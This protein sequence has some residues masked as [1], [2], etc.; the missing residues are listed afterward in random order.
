M[1]ILT[2]WQLLSNH[3]YNAWAD[4]DIIDLRGFQAEI[5]RV[6]SRTVYMFSVPKHHIKFTMSR[7]QDEIYGVLRE[8][9]EDM[10]DGTHRGIENIRIRLPWEPIFPEV[11]S[12][13]E[14][15]LHRWETDVNSRPP[16]P[17][18]AVLS[19]DRQNIHTGPVN[20]MANETV[21]LLCK[22]PI[23]AGQRTT[24]EIIAAWMEFTKK[25]SPKTI[26]IH[27]DMVTWGKKETVINE[28][29]YLYRRV[30]RGLWATIKSYKEKNYE[31]YCE[32]LIR[33]KEETRESL[34]MCAQGHISRLCNVMV[35]FDDAF[36]PP[37]PPMEIFQE[38]MAAIARGE[39][40]TEEKVAEAKKIMDE[41]QIPEVERDAWLGAF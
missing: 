28:G 41:F 10:L 29:D 16:M 23:P 18:L 4:G 36:K 13:L 2:E 8:E 35:G 21:E 33:L 12:R 25:C 19:H 17:E 14:A 40:E 30:L 34:G 6:T 32:L 26:K 11:K 37:V 39:A 27:D 38:K 7:L 24:D 3:L 5:R 9:Y 22:V 1:P 15:D 31:V 20:K